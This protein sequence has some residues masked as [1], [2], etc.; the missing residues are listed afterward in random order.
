M[1]KGIDYTG[2]AVAFICHD[3]RGNFLLHKRTEKCRDEH[4]KWDNG[5]GGLEFGEH[6]EEGMWRELR[7]EYGCDGVISE[8]LPVRSHVRDNNGVKT[9][10]VTFA[11]IVQV[12]PREAKINEP[13]SMADMGWFT[14]D[15][16][17][18]PLH[19]IA[20][21]QFQEWETIFRKYA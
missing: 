11:Y 13:E 17:P 20:A 6:P 4:H 14:L 2:V 18:Q 16:L 3:G 5:G 7:E 10:W 9:H 19:T 15:N 21:K 8:Q 1:Q 12:D